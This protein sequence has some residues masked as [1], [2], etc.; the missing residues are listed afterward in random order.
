MSF[1]LYRRPGAVVFLDDDLDYL[2]MLVEVMPDSWLVHLMLRPAACIDMLLEETNFREL[3]LWRQ[4][5]II[6]RWREG[7]ALIPQILKYWRDDGIARFTL[8]QVCV[9]DYSMPAMSGL[10]VLDALTRWSGSRILLTG[11][12]DEQLAV[13][14]FNSGLIQQFIPKQSVDIRQRLT[15]AIQRLLH[16]SNLRHDQT[17][18][19]TFSRP[20]SLLLSD[21]VISI[22]LEKLASKQG[23][24]EHVAIGAPFGILALDALAQ[25][26]WLQLEPADR[27]PELAEMAESEGF[28]TSTVAHIRSG[29][30][31]VDLEL[32]LALGSDQKARPREAFTIGDGTSLL[33]AALF[34]V[35][36]AF[37]PQPGDSYQQF[38]S[39]NS[40][41]QLQ[42]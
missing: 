35:S 27:L 22:A 2:E 3:D 15:D 23:W 39:R 30:K 41:R 9:V 42:D 11:R 14:A 16:T 17:W 33:Y 24:V 5:D 8:A 21:P 31:L 25:I 40:N 37:C 7:S 19:A 20:Q 13:S 28:D 38:L 34:D 26:M 10:K 32:Q 18:R 1:P 6:N 36:E 12:A 4:Q 29:K